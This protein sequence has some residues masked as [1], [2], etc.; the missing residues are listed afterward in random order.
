MPCTAW[1]PMTTIRTT[2]SQRPGWR[3]GTTRLRTTSSEASP[4][5][6][7]PRAAVSTMPSPLTS[8]FSDRVDEGLFDADLAHAPGIENGVVGALLDK[9]VERVRDQLGQ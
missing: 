9:L 5:S 3:R 6:D 7:R 1:K 4:R 2:T 8:M